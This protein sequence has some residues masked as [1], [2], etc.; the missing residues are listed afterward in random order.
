MLAEN[1]SPSLPSG[2]RSCLEL[3]QTEL[4]MEHS[5]TEEAKIGNLVSNLERQ[6]QKRKTS[7]DMGTSSILRF[8]KGRNNSSS[9]TLEHGDTRILPSSA[10]GQD[11]QR[12]E[13]W[14]YRNDEIDPSVIDEL[15]P[16]IQEEI[17]AWLR[18][19][20]RPSVPKHGSSI[21]HYFSPTKNT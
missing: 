18:P 9:Q 4:K 6:Q 11:S 20:K 12:R 16:E 19:L 21:D 10:T 15:P 8:F 13:A 17:R 14:K 5:R 2:S 3:N 7:K 1:K